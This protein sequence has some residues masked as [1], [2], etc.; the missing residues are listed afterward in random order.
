[1][2]ALTLGDGGRWWLALLILLLVRTGFTIAEFLAHMTWWR[3]VGRSVSVREYV[4]WLRANNMPPRIKRFPGSD[5]RP[6]LEDVAGW[7]L[8][9]EKEY[10]TVS[11]ATRRAA[12]AALWFMKGKDEVRSLFAKLRDDYALRLATHQYLS[13]RAAAS[14]RGAEM[15]SD[16][17]AAISKQPLTVEIVRQMDFQDV[18]Y[19]EAS[20]PGAMGNMGGMVIEVV[21][22]DALVRY[23]TNIEIDEAA[24]NAAREKVKA[25]GSLFDYHYGG[26]GNDA[27]LRKQAPIV[28]DEAHERFVFL[29]GSKKF[30]FSSSVS[31]VFRRVAASIKHSAQAQ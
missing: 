17:G 16:T 11:D 18:I 2:I 6:Y 15:P 30:P 31:G 21:K 22:G 4:D 8:R 14:T 13:E 3:L 9:H 25:N 27:Y 5:G 28:V 10:E 20:S 23:E 12:E 29:H 1:M 26:F 19:I 24:W 7:H